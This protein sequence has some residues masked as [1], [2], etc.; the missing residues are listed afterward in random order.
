MLFS[1]LNSGHYCNYTVFSLMQQCR[2]ITSHFVDPLPWI[3]INY[4]FVCNKN[5]YCSW[6]REVLE[7]HLVDLLSQ[8]LSRSSSK[9][10]PF[11]TLLFRDHWL[12]LLHLFRSFMFPPFWLHL[13][14]VFRIRLSN[15]AD[16]EVI[17]VTVCYLQPPPPS[18]H[19]ETRLGSTA[20]HPPISLFVHPFI[21]PFIQPVASGPWFRSST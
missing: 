12:Q 15:V 9:V 20:E 7:K 19:S 4:Q 2:Q 13:R 18:S 8:K 16:E 3:K 5:F 1:I 14:C 21:H 10:V 6:L 17:S 11:H